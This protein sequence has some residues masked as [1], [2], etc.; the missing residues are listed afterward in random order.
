MVTFSQ[1][2][3][4]VALKTGDRQEDLLNNLVRVENIEQRLEDETIIPVLQN[5]YQAWRAN[6]E[7]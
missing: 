4:D 5:A 3:Y 1:T 7:V 2:P 6:L